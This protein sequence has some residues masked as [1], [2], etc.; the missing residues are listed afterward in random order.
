MLASLVIDH[1]GLMG[2]APKPIA[3]GRLV[4]VGLILVGAGIVQAHSVAAPPPIAVQF[5]WNSAEN[6]IRQVALVSRPVACLDRFPMQRVVRRLGQIYHDLL[7][8]PWPLNRLSRTAK[9]A[10]TPSATPIQPTEGRPW[11]RLSGRPA[12]G[13]S[14]RPA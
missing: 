11:P 14:V 8:V 4:G 13:A 2:L 5:R 6:R 10:A 9:R 1:F 12:R 7:R 3:L